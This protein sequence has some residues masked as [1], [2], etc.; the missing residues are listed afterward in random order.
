M[1]SGLFS[2]HCNSGDTILNY[3]S[4]VSGLAFDGE[5][6]CL[7]LFQS[8]LQT[9][10]FQG[11]SLFAHDN[12]PLP[13]RKQEPPDGIWGQVYFLVIAV[14]ELGVTTLLLHCL[15]IRLTEVKC[16]SR[17]SAISR[18]LYPYSSTASPIFWSLIP[19]SRKTSL[20]V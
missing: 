10:H 8:W 12:E 18:C 1:G 3:L 14:W 19:L 9:F 16:R 11:V 15:K 5:A 7:M 17:W 13:S 4:F 6:F 20:E 2:C